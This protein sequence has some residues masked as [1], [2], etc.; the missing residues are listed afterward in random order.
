MSETPPEPPPVLPTSGPATLGGVKQRANI[1]DGQDDSDLELLVAAVN[2]AIRRWPVA[3]LALGPPPGEG[4]PDLTWPDDIVLGANMLG[5]RL[6]RR[7]DTVG[8]V[9]IYGEAGIAYVRRTD[10]DIAML[11]QL[12]DW[13]KPA[14]G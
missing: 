5:A 7:K 13:S 12:G 14:V 8:G 3:Q 6:W 10:P 4:D 2:S 11:L 1:R 9:E